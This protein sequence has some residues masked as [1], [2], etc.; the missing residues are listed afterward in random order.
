MQKEKNKKRKNTVFS[1]RAIKLNLRSS[2]CTPRPLLPLQNIVETQIACKKKGY[3]YSAI[4]NEPLVQ[5][6]KRNL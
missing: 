6:T 3:L 1:S 4:S 2:I 5:S